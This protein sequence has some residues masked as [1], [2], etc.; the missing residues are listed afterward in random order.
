M[1]RPTSLRAIEA[2]KLRK[3]GLTFQAIADRF[4]ITRQGAYQ[5]IHREHVNKYRYTKRLVNKLVKE[6]EIGTGY[7]SD[8]STSN[9]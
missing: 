5:L 3:E 6:K 8:S 9:S 7:F 4:G 1:A 2:Q